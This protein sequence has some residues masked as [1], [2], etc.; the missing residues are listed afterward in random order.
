[1]GADCQKPRVYSRRVADGAGAFRARRMSRRA[2][3]CI[4]RMRSGAQLVGGA[5]VQRFGWLHA[6]TC[7]CKNPYTKAIH[8]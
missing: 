7:R 6:I 4:V 2:R 8:K 1:M 5:S 3:P